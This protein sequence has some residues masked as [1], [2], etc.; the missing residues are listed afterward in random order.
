MARSKSS[1]KWLKEHFSDQYVKQAQTEGYRSR[2]AYKLLELQKKYSLIQ[3][4]MAV[5]DLGA[6][7]GGWSQ[8]VVNVLNHTGRVIALDI[9]PFA[10]IDGVEV[11]Q[12]DFSEELV[13]QELLCKL[14]GSKVNLILSDIAPNL[15]GIKAVDQARAVYLAELVLDFAERALAQKGGMLVKVFQGE[16]FDHYFKLLKSRFEQVLTCKPDASRGRSR[17]VYLLARS[18]RF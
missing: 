10:P 13:F 8:V 14:Q 2:S 9:L 5:V 18:S 4:H 1:K 11:I 17:E 12:G 6:A 7:P 16:G 15:S 3:S